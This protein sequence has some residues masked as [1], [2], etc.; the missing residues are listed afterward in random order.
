MKKIILTATVLGGLFMAGCEQDTTLTIKDVPVV[1]TKTVS[2]S[3]D[4][5]PLFSKNCALSGCHATG[6]HSPI[7]M[8]DN[9]Y[10]SLTVGGFINLKDPA[11]SKI[12]ERLTGVLSPAMPMGRAS[13]PSNINSLVLAWIKQGAKKN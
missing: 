6:G 11:S 3:K 10:T 7:L 4:L 9:A 5:I 8:S 2:L 1:V 12:Y 13:N